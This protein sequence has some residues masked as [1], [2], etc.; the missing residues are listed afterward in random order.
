MSRAV[1]SLTHG[2]A[3][4]LMVM[5]PANDGLLDWLG[6]VAKTFDDWATSLDGGDVEDFFAYLN[7]T[8]P[9]VA[10]AAGAIA[11]AILQIVEAAAPMGGPVLDSI[12][13][14]A[15]VIST[16]ADSPLGAP[17][18]T[19]VTAVSALSLA[20]RGLD[21]ILASV[22][23][24][25]DALSSSGAS[26]L[27]RLAATM[28]TISG[29][30]S[31]M[32]TAFEELAGIRLDSGSLAR[33]LEAL[34]DGRV[35]KNFDDLFH[36]FQ[37][38]DDLWMAKANPIGWI[39]SW[40]PTGAEA[41]QKNIKDLDSALASMVEGGNADQAARAWEELEAIGIDAGRS[42]K[43]LTQLFPEYA[44]ALG[45]V[46]DSSHQAS[47]A[48]EALGE[49][50]GLV[51]A[52]LLASRDAARES[53]KAF[54]E[55]SDS[56]AG[57]RFSLSGW[58]QGFEDQVRAVADFR[59]NIQALRE[60]GLNASV[61]D[62]LI[63]QGPA[64]AQA[65]AG[66]AD[67]GEGAIRRLNRAA[68]QG[69][70]EV[71][72]MG[73]DAKD[74]E[75]GLFDLG[76]AKVIPFVDLNPAG[77]NAKLRD[78][79]DGLG[80]TGKRK[81]E[82]S[83][84]L[85]DGAFQRVRDQVA[86]SLATLDGKTAT[87]HVKAQVD[88]AYSRL[89]G[90]FGGSAN[91]STIPDDGGGY[92][93]YLPYLL[94]PREEVVSNRD[95]QAD[96]FRPELKDINAGLPRMIVMERMILR[97][98]AQPER[99]ASGSPRIRGRGQDFQALPMGMASFEAWLEALEESRDAL[100]DETEARQSLAKELGEGAAGRF[101]SDLF[102]ETDPW[103]RGGSLL[104]AINTLN[105][106][107]A[108]ANAY[109]GNVD[110]LK[111]LGL[112]DPGALQALLSQADAATVANIAST[113]TPELVAQYEQAFQIR[114][115]TTAALSAQVQGMQVAAMTAQQAATN[116]KLDQLNAQIRDLNAAT[117]AEHRADRDA[118]RKGAGQIKRAP[119][120]GKGPVL[121]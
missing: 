27:S 6:D 45:N 37:D 85:N 67:A 117:K 42:T 79:N 115:N 106:D 30:A 7:E 62:S 57:E 63:T 15:N 1:G 119:K 38:I 98:S 121:R 111:G 16:I 80:R 72:G 78:V 14:I 86:N 108:G 20:S 74:A 96:E 65:V 101:T 81:V 87:V 91:G 58:L 68:R 113:A 26:G 32:Q 51:E 71:R 22:R 109:S 116:A 56:I 75:A 9:K 84:D 88:G 5:D 118:S 66:L 89:K 105:G 48:T 2:L 107:T 33:D 69:R 83:I 44:T 64:A 13:A 104:D 29:S 35:T 73:R 52:K 95:G 17:L 4:L 46:A 100:N 120:A 11:N 94:A 112:D 60:K 59:D 92:R 93:D 61:I 19:A 12:T 39:S 99:A 82:P 90:F 10:D 24:N 8:G 40:D 110:R 28:V 114:S 18:M 97:S 102:G 41:A 49:S 77:F 43:E 21:T 54:V 53:G 50:Q 70:D 47:A 25:I 103:S 34:A 3:E 31:L 76:N 23:G 55:F 36:T